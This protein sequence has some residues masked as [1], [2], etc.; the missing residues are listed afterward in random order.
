[1]SEVATIAVF[2]EV[3]TRHRYS[4]HLMTD[5]FRTFVGEACQTLFRKAGIRHSTIPPH[6]LAT[7]GAAENLVDTQNQMYVADGA[8]FRRCGKAIFI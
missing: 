5:N 6:Y 8:K 7:N 1:M 3:F 4:A 2:K